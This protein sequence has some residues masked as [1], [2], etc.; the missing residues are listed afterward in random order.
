MAK[1]ERLPPVE[2]KNEIKA[3]ASKL[4]LSKGFSATTMEN[5]VESVTLSKGGVYRI[6]PS[7]KAILT[8]IILDGM[9]LRNEMYIQGT[10]KYLSAGK[11][12][13]SDA[14]IRTICDTM[15]IGEEYS[16]LYAIFLYEGMYYPELRALY[17]EIVRQTTEETLALAKEYQIRP[18]LSLSA[19]DFALLTD[20]MNTAILGI[21]ILDARENYQKNITLFEASLGRFFDERQANEGN[22]DNVETIEGRVYDISGVTMENKTDE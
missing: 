4:F 3:A 21:V 11:P 22:Y 20:M 2:R 6:Y 19:G 14:L 8:D 16:R 5:I 17:E 9:H 15:L 18:L 10:T 13:D 12:L 1:F 7:T